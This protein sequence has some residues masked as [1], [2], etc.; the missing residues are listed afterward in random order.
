MVKRLGW[1][2]DEFNDEKGRERA[3]CGN[4]GMNVHRLECGAVG[5]I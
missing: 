4:G 5:F 1:D 3:A 2:E